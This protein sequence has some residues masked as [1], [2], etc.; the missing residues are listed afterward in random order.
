MAPLD[1][2]RIWGVAVRSV[3]PICGIHRMFAV[4]CSDGLTKAD[5]LEEAEP[6][7]LDWINS[8]GWDRRK[9]S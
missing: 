3:E 7:L 1:C 9:C 5:A 4:R 6:Q 8:E 2:G